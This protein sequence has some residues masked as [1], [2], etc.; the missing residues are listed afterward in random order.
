VSQT[1]QQAMMTTFF[2]FFPAMLFSASSSD[3]QHAGSHS[4]AQLADPL[5]YFLIII[6]GIFLKG[7]VSSCCGRSSPLL[8]IGRS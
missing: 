2:F 7:S 1:Q 4:V 5:R 3:R 6:R 8:V